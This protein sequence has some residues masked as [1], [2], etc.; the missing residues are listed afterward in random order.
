MST[1][2]TNLLDNSIAATARCIES[3]K[4]IRAEIDRAAELILKTV[5]SGNK[6]L[7]CGNGGSAAEAQHFSTELV[8]RY[9][10]NRRS[11]PSVALNAD[12]SLI[13]CIGNDY[14]FDAAFSRQIEGLAKPGD[15][16]IGITSSGNSA[17]ILA[18]L[19]TAKKLG[20]ESISFLGRGG[21]KAR[22]MA[23]VDLIIPG[24]SGRCA[25]EAHLFLVHHFCDLIDAAVE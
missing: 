12:G 15:V 23:T 20:L 2:P 10:K 3:L 22:G 6:L 17:N 13:T 8:G 19:E 1:T 16:V 25:Q 14:G 7:I 5:R 11:L 4:E 21:G 24:D 18:A 9:F